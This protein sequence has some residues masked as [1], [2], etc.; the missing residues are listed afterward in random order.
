MN[1][2]LL[3]LTAA[4]ASAPKAPPSATISSYSGTGCVELAVIRPMP[5]DAARA[6]VPA[7]YKLAPGPDGLAQMSFA[8]Y[9][10]DSF[11]IDGAPAPGG[12]VGEHSVRIEAPD[13]SPG[14]HAWLLHHAT[15]VKP[16]A[17]GL[18]GVSETFEVAQEGTFD[19]GPRMAGGT[20]VARGSIRSAH[21]E[22]SWTGDP[23]K[24][25]A[26]GPVDHNSKGV[27]FWLERDGRRITLDYSSEI[28]P[29]S[30]GTITIR[31]GGAES[32][33]T[34]AFLRFEPKVLIKR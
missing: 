8:L 22:A 31:S 7:R 30:T 19:V 2:L 9:R 1:R 17:E 16:L 25:P 12:I 15:T 20:N 33:A 10:C 4:C 34:G 23:V 13:G 24:E 6:L 11:A 3:I 14:R 32:T 28:L 18:G 5:L 26:D 29:R 21:F 27:T